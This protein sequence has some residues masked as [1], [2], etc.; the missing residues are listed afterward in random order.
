MLNLSA[1]EVDRW[2]RKRTSRM[3]EVGRRNAEM[4]DA[5]GRLVEEVENRMLA[6]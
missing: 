1:L 6:V 3:L 4:L 2:R 5:G